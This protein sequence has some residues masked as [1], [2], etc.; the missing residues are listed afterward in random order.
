MTFGAAV[1]T[2]NVRSGDLGTSTDCDCGAAA[3]EEEEED[4]A[5]VTGSASS[6]CC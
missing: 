4:E 6:L 3:A 1:A 2:G 5:I